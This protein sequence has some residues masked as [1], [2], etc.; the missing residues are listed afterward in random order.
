MGSVTDQPILAAKD[1][2]RE[3]EKG[4][5]APVEAT[6]FPGG[7]VRVRRLRWFVLGVGHGLMLVGVRFA[8]WEKLDGLR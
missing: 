8:G 5:H 1:Q 6:G 4:E 7:A 3:A 2:D